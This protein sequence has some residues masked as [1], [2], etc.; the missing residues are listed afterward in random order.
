MVKRMKTALLLIALFAFP[1]FSTVA[2][3]EPQFCSGLCAGRFV[4]SQVTAFQSQG[5]LLSGAVH[6]QP[7]YFMGNLGLLPRIGVTP[8][9]NVLGHLFW[10]FDGAL[11]AEWRFGAS[12]F[13][14]NAG[15]GYTYWVGD[16]TLNS[17]QLQAGARY[18]LDSPVL[19]LIHRF[20]LNVALP[21]LSPAT[22]FV[23]LGA[24]IGF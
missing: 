11:L 2:R 17:F 6:W 19:G 20:Q 16:W 12:G 3:A 22:F 8:I 21:M 15:P 14:V 1:H 9:E 24:G 10:D 5:F 7:E 4:I 23:N 13:S 18:E